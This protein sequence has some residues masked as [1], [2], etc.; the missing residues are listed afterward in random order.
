MCRK[1]VYL[2]RI[3]NCTMAVVHSSPTTGLISN[4]MEKHQQQTNQSYNDNTTQACRSVAHRD[5]NLL[6]ALQ[7]NSCALHGHLCYF[8]RCVKRRLVTSIGWLRISRTDC[9]TN[10]LARKI[11]FHGQGPPDFFHF[12]VNSDGASPF[13]HWGILLESGISLSQDRP[14]PVL[15]L[16]IWWW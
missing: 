13:G 12:G 7:E 14:C 3:Q 9:G 10:N 6:L 11:I 8:C 2:H 15:Y 1:R 5:P 4:W 16:T